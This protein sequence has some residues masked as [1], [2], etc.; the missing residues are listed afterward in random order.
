MKPNDPNV[1]LLERAA[2]A[3]DTPRLA[4]ALTWAED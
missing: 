1:V 3:W 2:E 4:T